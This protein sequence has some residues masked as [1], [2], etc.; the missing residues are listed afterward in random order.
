MHQRPTRVSLIPNHLMMLV[1]PAHTLSGACK[2]CHTAYSAVMCPWLG[3]LITQTLIC[4][5]L[6]IFCFP[7]QCTEAGYP[8]HWPK[9]PPFGLYDVI[10]CPFGGGMHPPIKHFRGLHA[11]SNN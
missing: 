9:T 4:R 10:E 5:N 7:I 2:V 6:S 11:T 3:Y 8:N 1:L